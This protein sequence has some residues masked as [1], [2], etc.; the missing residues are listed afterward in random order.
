MRN[1]KA[2]G[3]AELGI[4]RSIN[5]THSSRTDLA[6]DA[7]VGQRSSGGNVSH[8]PFTLLRSLPQEESVSRTT[9]NLLQIDPL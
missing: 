6:D 2:T 4:L 5:F 9:I 3:R 7:I 1:F 8:G